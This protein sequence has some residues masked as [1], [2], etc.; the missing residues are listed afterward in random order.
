[1]LNF[2]FGRRNDFDE[3]ASRTPSLQY[4][5]LSEED[6]EKALNL[7]KA[8]AIQ[9]DRAKRYCAAV[10][11]A[12]VHEAQ[13]RA[14]FVRNFG[15]LEAEVRYY[16]ESAQLEADGQTRKYQGLLANQREKLKLIYRE[17]KKNG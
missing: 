1:M 5:E 14:E 8:M 13:A 4:R 11:S 10:R 3:I 2:L 15:G 9:L 12:V 16:S 6:V 7:E 17:A